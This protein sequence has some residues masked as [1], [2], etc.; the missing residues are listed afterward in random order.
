MLRWCGFLSGILWTMA[1]FLRAAEPPPSALPDLAG[2]TLVVFN[3]ADPDSPSLAETYAKARSIPSDRVIGLDCALTEEITRS[4]FE[5]TIRKPLE[6]LFQSRGWMKR[7][8]NFLPNPVL[9]LEG[10]VPVQ[11][12]KDNPIWIMVLID[13]KSTCLNSSHEWISRM[14]SSA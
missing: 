13:R 4:D 8:E 3:K 7:Q 6:E 5:A 14:P 9:G 1:S 12:S 10:T 11:Q 2:H